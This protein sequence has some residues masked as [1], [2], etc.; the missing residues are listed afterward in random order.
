M[1]EPVCERFNRWKQSGKAVKTIR[2]DNAGENKGLEQ[3]MNSSAWKLD[4]TPEY[5]ARDTP[6]QNHLAELSLAKMA[7]KGRA[8]M[9]A[10]HVPQ[11]IRYR[12]FREAMT[13]ATLLDN[14]MVVSIDGKE[15]T[16]FEHFAGKNPRFLQHL[17]TWGEAGTV[18]LKTK[19]TPKIGNRGEQCMFVGYATRIACG[20]PKPVVYMLLEM[21]FG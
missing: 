20:I 1:I 9:V 7:A 12:L 15:G 3:R 17:R 8:L 5:T 13:T 21:S 14:L 16:R 2:M 11:S 19:A 4:I 18:K 10:A 6:Q